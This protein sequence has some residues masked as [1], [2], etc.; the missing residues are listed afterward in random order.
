MKI[1]LFYCFF[2]IS[3]SFAT[4]CRVIGKDAINAC[5]EIGFKLFN[6]PDGQRSAGLSELHFNGAGKKLFSGRKV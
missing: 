5:L 1:E 2:K 6:A 3:D 4:E